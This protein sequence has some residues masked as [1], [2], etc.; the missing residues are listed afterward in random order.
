MY[1]TFHASLKLRST[2]PNI[3]EIAAIKN[4]Y[5]IPLNQIK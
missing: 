2:I 3:I 5:S 4:K 1:K